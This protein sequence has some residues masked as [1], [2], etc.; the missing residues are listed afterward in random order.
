MVSIMLWN[1]LKSKTPKHQTALHARQAKGADMSLDHENQGESGRDDDLLRCIQA[2]LQ[3]DYMV[4]PAGSDKV[5][6]ALGGLIE[7]LCKETQAEMSGVV[8]LSVQASETA[9]FSANMLSSLCEVDDQARGIAAAAEEMVATVN[10]IGSYGQ[11]IAEQAQDTQRATLLGAEASQQAVQGM[12]RI[13][14]SVNQS[15]EKV[16]ILNEFSAR[17][18]KIAEDIK[19]I[20][21][22]TN[23]LALNATIE[24]ARAG[25]AGKGFAVVA[26]EVKNL[27]GQT[28]ASTEEVNEII[29]HLRQETK[30]ILASM[31]DSKNAV[32]SGQEA[33]QNVGTRMEEIQ[34]KIEEVTK[35]TAQISNILIEQKQASQEVAKGITQIASSSSKSVKGIEKIVD[36]MEIVEK[37]INAQIARMSELEVPNKVIKLA[38]SDHVL[39]K[40]RLANMVIGREGLKPDELADHHTCRLGKWYDDVSDPKYKNNAAFKQ[41]VEP[42]KL[43]HEYGIQAVRYFNDNNMKGALAEIAKVETTSKQVLELLVEL[44]KEAV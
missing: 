34:G 41:L 21:D 10:E 33:I 19:K 38:Q 3:G 5:S 43:V 35:N 28:R 18:G 29:E 15:V 44:E 36:A 4:S 7:K 13:T 42:H 14:I 11:N 6:R 40:K 27:S 30:E 26:G 23:L 39:W 17:I 16:K 24:A 37:L 1:K 22:Q 32:S 9:I 31:E 2:V 12:E 25:E 8:G 20:A